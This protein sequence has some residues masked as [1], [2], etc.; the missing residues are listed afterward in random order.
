MREKWMG[1]ART[2]ENARRYVD[3]AYKIAEC[4]NE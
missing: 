4:C 3:H 1:S 2:R